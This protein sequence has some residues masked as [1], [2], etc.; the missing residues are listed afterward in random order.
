MTNEQFQLDAFEYRTASAARRA[1]LEK[2]WGA[3]ADYFRPEPGT[4]A[5]YELTWLDIA[6]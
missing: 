1:E 5:N 4:E 3:R 2:K 6:Y